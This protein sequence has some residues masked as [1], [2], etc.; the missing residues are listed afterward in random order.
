LKWGDSN[1]ICLFVVG[2]QSNNKAKI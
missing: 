1:A 2:L